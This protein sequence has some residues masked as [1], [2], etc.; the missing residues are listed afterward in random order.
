MY[1]KLLESLTFPNKNG[2]SAHYSPRQIVHKTTLSYKD[3]LH[4]LGSFVQAHDEPEPTNSQA[5][6]S[7]DSIYVRKPAGVGHD[8]YDLQTKHIVN[9]AHVTVLPISPSVIKAVEGIAEVEGQKGLRIKTHMVNII[10][11]SSWTVGEDY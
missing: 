11:E 7:L 6:R 3:C 5:A 4:S 8:A 9:R 1:L 2:I 10:Y